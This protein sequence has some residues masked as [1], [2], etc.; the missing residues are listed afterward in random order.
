MFLI[1]PYGMTPGRF[2]FWKSYA[3][4]IK[5]LSTFFVSWWLNKDGISTGNVREVFMSGLKKYLTTWID[6]Y[7]DFTH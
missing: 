1:Y 3:L 6:K 7:V 2:L 5:Y 4:S